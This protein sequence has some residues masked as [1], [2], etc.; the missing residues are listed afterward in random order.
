MYDHGVNSADYPYYLPVDPKNNPDLP[1]IATRKTELYTI[2]FQAFVMLQVFNE[3]NSRKLGDKE[4]NVFHRFFNN[5]LFIF[6]T[7]LTIGV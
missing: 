1:E 6:I 7:F 5:W 3:I 2:I 4:F